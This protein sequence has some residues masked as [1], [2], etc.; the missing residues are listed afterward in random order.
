M[1][2]QKAEELKRGEDRPTRGE[3]IP[4]EEVEKENNLVA[5]SSG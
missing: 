5:L 2:E 4:W 1:V 3:K